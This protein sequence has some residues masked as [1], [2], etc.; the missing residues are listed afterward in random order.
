MSEVLD[1]PVEL[2]VFD[3]SRLPLDWNQF[4]HHEI[5]TMKRKLDASKEQQV[6]QLMKRK[7]SSATAKPDG[8]TAADSVS[9]N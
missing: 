7:K 4:S 8:N 6:K 5:E 1:G 2:G 9:A 3:L